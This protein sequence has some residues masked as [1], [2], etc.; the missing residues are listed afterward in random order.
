MKAERGQGSP[1]GSEFTQPACYSLN[2]TETLPK[3]YSIVTKIG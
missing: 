2:L 1:F 3:H